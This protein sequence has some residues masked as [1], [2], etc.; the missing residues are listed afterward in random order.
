[1]GSSSWH[2]QGAKVGKG[3]VVDSLDVMDPA[4]LEIGDD[5]V[6]GEHATLLAHTFKDGHVTFHKVNLLCLKAGQNRDLITCVVTLMAPPICETNVIGII[7][8]LWQL[9]SSTFSAGLH[10]QRHQH[11]PSCGRD[12]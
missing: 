11:L 12:A 3:V 4:F 7:C 5:V 2:L 10:P 1:M 8:N 9:T 6:L